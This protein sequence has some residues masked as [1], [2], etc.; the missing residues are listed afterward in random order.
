MRDVLRFL[1]LLLLIAAVAAGIGAAHYVWRGGNA[2]DLTQPASEL[3]TA[4]RATASD[5]AS[6]VPDALQ[7]V[8]SAA[9]SDS[10]PQP[11]GSEAD[12]DPGEAIQV[13]FAPGSTI[14]PFDIDD[15]LVRLVKRAQKSVLCAFYDLELVPLAEALVSRFNA[16][17]EV[18]IV[19]DSDYADRNAL[20]RC[21]QAG[22]PVVF[23]ARAPFMHNKFCVVD[24]RWL[25]TG[26][27]NATENCMY[28]NDNNSVLID[29][30]ELSADYATEFDE[31]SRLR[32]FGKDGGSNLPYPEVVVQ[33]VRI[34]CRFAPENGVAKALMSEVRRANRTVDFMAFT[35]T[36]KDLA[37]AMVER[38]QK[39]ARVRALFDTQQAAS[40]YSQDD[41]LSER[42]VQVF[43][44]KNS[45]FMHNKVIIV[46]AETVV[47]GSY[48]FSKAAETKNDENVLIIHSP[49]IAKEYE[50]RFEALIR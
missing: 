2:G 13:Y 39:G 46:D 5:L 44:D 19:S 43:L 22:I 15:A 49:A 6:K 25:W 7:S 34:E 45:G 26:S 23:D 27:T 18:K 24:G 37:K 41:F 47:T 17:V 50:D 30:P 36:S 29:S 3:A 11:A 16:G 8:E 40:K 20:R 21:V 35:L 28:K 32:K 38:A 14:N 48:N 33:G 1:L 42:G 9:P 10:S 4:V 12:A 31:M